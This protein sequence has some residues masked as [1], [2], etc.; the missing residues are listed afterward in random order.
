MTRNRLYHVYKQE[1]DPA[2]FYG[3]FPEIPKSDSLTSIIELE[4][5]FLIPVLEKEKFGFIDGEGNSILPPSLPG[6]HPDYLCTY[7]KLD[8]IVSQEHS[9][10]T[11]VSKNGDI[12]YKGDFESAENLD[13]GLIKIK[14]EGKFGLIDK[15]GQNLLDFDYSDLDLVGGSYIKYKPF[16]REKWGLV[17]IT[18][19]TLFDPEFDNIYAK[20]K[21]ILFERDGKL[22]VSNT[23]QLE[24]LLDQ[25]L[26][27]LDFRFDE[28]ELIK[29]HYL[30]GFEGDREALLEPDLKP[31]I[32]F[33]DQEILDIPLGW[34][35][36]QG[37]DYQML[38]LD[39]NPFPGSPFQDVLYNKSWIALKKDQ[40]W[41]ILHQDSV[42]N[43]Q[44]EYDLVKLIS[45]QIIL[46]FMGNQSFARFS[47]GFL[48]TTTGKT[49]RLIQAK[50][51]EVPDH[52]QTIDE[53][54]IKR[55][56]NRN[57]KKILA[58]KFNN[59]RVLRSY[60]FIIDERGGERIV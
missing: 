52:L 19:K 9:L 39:F 58:G 43:P 25:N 29:D 31:I 36:D 18:N 22:A 27:E 12:L 26:V 34:L 30:L 13:Y 48:L 60:L 16:G 24:V 20:G 56:Y 51:P 8:F 47:N 5:T 37:K 54:G 11:L 4:E 6:L 45:E 57:G 21:F 15:T 50:D 1:N 23:A 41:A 38:D 28:T 49:V 55:L 35:L 14:E 3:K 40:K 17:S 59:V 2:D 46:L 32:P 44:Y 42:F 10:K 53:K 7:S 33:G